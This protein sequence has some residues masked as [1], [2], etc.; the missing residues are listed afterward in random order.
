MDIREDF[1][2]AMRIYLTINGGVDNPLIELKYRHRFE[3]LD[4]V[5][6]VDAAYR[7]KINRKG[8]IMN[9]IFNDSNDVVPRSL[10]EL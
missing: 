8:Y 3:V 10:I 6:G 7:E 2:E 4:E 9:S 5:M 1:A